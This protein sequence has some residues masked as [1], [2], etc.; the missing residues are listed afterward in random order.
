M[1]VNPY[2]LKLLL[3]GLAITLALPVIADQF[4]LS[5]I[6]TRA[7]VMGIVAASMSFLV[8]YLGV[9]HLRR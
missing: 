1:T 7:L 9:Y 6:I 8:T 5:Q 2:R 4:W 3:T